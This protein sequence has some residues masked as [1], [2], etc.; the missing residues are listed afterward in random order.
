VA[1]GYNI[2]SSPGAVASSGTLATGTGSSVQSTPC[3]ATSFAEVVIG[4]ISGAPKSTA[5]SP[6]PG[7]TAAST[8]LSAGINAA[9]ILEHQIVSTTGAY[10]ASAI[11]SPQ[12]NWAAFAVAL[13]DNT[14]PARSSQTVGALALGASGG[15]IPIPGIPPNMSVL[16]AMSAGLMPANVIV[17]GASAIVPSPALT[18]LHQL[19]VS[20]AGQ[21]ALIGSKLIQPNSQLAASA[22]N[23]LQVGSPPIFGG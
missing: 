16:A 2:S 12:G 10:A 14:Q 19:T 7:F 21:S 17:T 18:L 22:G 8:F 4:L 11:L 13:P 1:A 6:G 15:P 20:P 5:L 3:G 9:L 23:Q